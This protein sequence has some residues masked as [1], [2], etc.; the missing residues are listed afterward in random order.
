MMVVNGYNSPYT[1]EHKEWLKTYKDSQIPYSQL[2]KMFNEKFNMNLNKNAFYGL[3]VRNGFKQRAKSP[4]WFTEEQR[5][6]IFDNYKNKKESDLL[7]EL[8]QKFNESFTLQKIQDFKKRNKLHSGIKCRFAK[9]GIPWCVGISKEER[10]KHYDLEELDKIRRKNVLKWK[11]YK[12][13][14]FY[15]SADGFKYIIVNTDYGVPWEKRIKLYAQCVWEEHYGKMPPK[16][17]IIY[18][19][20]NKLNCDISNL[21]CVS[22]KEIMHLT[23]NDAFN[24]N[25]I[26]ETFLDIFKA[27]EKIKEITNAAH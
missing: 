24:K 22:M 16:H 7:E 23:R 11:K 15:I 10:A 8:N 17:K 25:E 14:D 13:G 27:Q 26:T 5:K 9:G 20:G 4:K 19:D 3:C 12:V 2:M 21:L 6:Y 18:K 1:S